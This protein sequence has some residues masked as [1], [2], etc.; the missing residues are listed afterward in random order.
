MCWILISLIFRFFFVADFVSALQRQQASA[1]RG[2]QASG[3]PDKTPRKQFDFDDN[4]TEANRWR[5]F[6]NWNCNVPPAT[7]AGFEITPVINATIGQSEDRVSGV[8][9]FGGIRYSE[10]EST[11]ND[12]WFFNLEEQLWSRVKTKTNPPPRHNHSMVTL[13]G[14]TIVLIGGQ[15]F[16]KT[17]EDVWIFNTT[18]SEWTEVKP[19]GTKAPTPPYQSVARVIPDTYT[20]CNCNQSVVMPQRDSWSKLWALRCIRDQS[21]YDWVSLHNDDTLSQG[22]IKFTASARRK[23]LI[24]GLAEK[25]LWTYSFSPQGWAKAHFTN[26]LTTQ[27]NMTDRMVYLDKEDLLLL[28]GTASESL[29]I[30]IFKLN[31][32]YFRWQKGYAVGNIPVRLTSM[33]QTR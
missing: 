29:E 15:D 28:I 16:G 1:G 12:T 20:Q 11:V 21:Q 30:H 10:D 31:E 27:N 19:G 25:S 14:E 22:E 23:G 6:D 7:T 26:I 5:I 3:L 17:F 2:E 4:F 8:L 32:K 13:C 24:Y 9:L 33:H 18:T